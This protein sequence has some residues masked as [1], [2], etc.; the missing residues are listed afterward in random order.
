MISRFCRRSE[1]RVKA[2]LLV[3]TLI[4]SSGWKPTLVTRVADELKPDRVLVIHTDHPRTLKCLE[5]SRRALAV[6]VES[7]IVAPAFD[8][9]KWYR[10]VEG[11]VSEDAVFN[12]TAGHGV[13]ISVLSL[14]AAQRGLPAVIYDDDANQLHHLSPG[15]LFTM[16]NLG[17]VERSILTE[18]AAGEATSQLLVERTGYATGT[19]SQ[20]LTRLARDGYVVSRYE[21][22]QRFTQMRQGV[23]TF[24]HGVLASST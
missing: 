14:V 19:V 15:I 13:A 4:T 5:E 10:E 18:L 12:L 9:T 17:R 3:T 22:R 8:F 1:E 11:H 23:R 16:D 21:G 24:L 2:P 20:A 7:H 6:P